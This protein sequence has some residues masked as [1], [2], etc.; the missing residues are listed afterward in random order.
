MADINHP[1]SNGRTHS[2]KTARSA[3]L[4][5]KMLERGN[6]LFSGLMAAMK[7]D[8]A[9]GHGISTSPEDFGSNDSQWAVQS[10]Y[11]A[12]LSC[13]DARAPT[14]MILHQGYNDLYVVRVAGNVLGRECLGSLKYAA[15][16]FAESLKLLAVLGHANCCAIAAAVDAYLD[17]GKYLRLAGNYPLRTIID[18]IIV[19]VRTADLGLQTLHGPAVVAQPEYRNALLELG[20]AL[21]AAWTA[22]SLREELT[23]HPHRN[24]KIVFGVYD[25]DSHRLGLMPSMDALPMRRGFLEA[26]RGGNEF[27]EL[28]SE[29]CAA[30]NLSRNTRVSV[31]GRSVAGT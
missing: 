19:S 12:I 18:Q 17:P 26:P 27:R 1:T 20:V 13:S 28:V 2:R 21:N 15:D 14:E 9:R 11:A 30:V 3:T 6:D 8:Q 10:P 16:Q 7:A 5:Q 31:A 29:L 24:L 23:G 4:A 22:F 25:L